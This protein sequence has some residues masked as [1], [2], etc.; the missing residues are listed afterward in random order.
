MVYMC[1]L[2][3]FYGKKGNDT[4]YLAI[5][6]VLHVPLTADAKGLTDEQVEQEII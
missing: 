2:F 6:V 5:L 3:S 1:R 4:R